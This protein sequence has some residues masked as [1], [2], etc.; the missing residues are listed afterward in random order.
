MFLE[1]IRAWVYFVCLFCCMYDWVSWVGCS[2]V[3]GWLVLVGCWRAHGGMPCVF[4]VGEVN[5]LWDL[6]EVG[7]AQ[8]NCAVMSCPMGNVMSSFTA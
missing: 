8:C 4:F 3:W 6:V 7:M 1:S 5:V 2:A